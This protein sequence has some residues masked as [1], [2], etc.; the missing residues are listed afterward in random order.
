MKR[1]LDHRPAPRAIFLYN[2]T[3]KRLLLAGLV[4]LTITDQNEEAGPSHRTKR[5]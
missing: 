2:E 4:D 5:S 3:K 1:F